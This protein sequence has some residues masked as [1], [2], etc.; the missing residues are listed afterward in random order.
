MIAILTERDPIVH[1][2]VLRLVRHAAGRQVIPIRS[3]VKGSH[4]ELDA[5]NYYGHM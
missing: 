1:E 4:D 2:T 5:I 3:I